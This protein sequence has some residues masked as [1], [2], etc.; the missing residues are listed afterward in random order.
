MPGE[1]QRGMRAFLDK[2]C[3]KCHGSDN[4][5]WKEPAPRNHPTQQG[6]PT[7]VW[8]A[9]CNTCHDGAASTAH[10]E[11]QTV[12]GVESCGVCHGTGA[13]FSVEVMHRVR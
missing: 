1:P 5:A 4:D 11:A 9:T 12:G 3:A 13:E 6:D 10:I 8:K 7:L 2:G